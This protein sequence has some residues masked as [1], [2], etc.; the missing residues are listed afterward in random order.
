MSAMQS[1]DMWKKEFAASLKGK[2]ALNALKIFDKEIPW[3]AIKDKFPMGD[4]FFERLTEEVLFAC[5]N[6]YRYEIL[7]KQDYYAKS[8]ALHN[9]HRKNALQYMRA[10]KQIISGSK[11]ENFEEMFKTFL[12]APIQ[13]PSAGGGKK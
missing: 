2:E 13:V 8:R 1:Y 12:T 9:E 6:A 5:Y 10:I 11:D 7:K 3:L 4:C